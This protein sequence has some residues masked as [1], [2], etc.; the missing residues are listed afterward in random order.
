[1]QQSTRKILQV[2]SRESLPFHWHN[3]DGRREVCIQPCGGSWRWSGGFR[4]DEVNNFG[5]KIRHQNKNRFKIMP[6]DISNKGDSMVCIVN[7][8]HNDPPYRVENRLGLS[9]RGKVSLSSLP[10][11]CY[12]QCC[13]V[14]NIAHLT[15][16]IVA[17]VLE[18]G[19]SDLQQYLQCLLGH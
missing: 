19:Q 8:E 3:A 6:I 9:A 1:M 13:L 15:L 4:L 2:K 7:E 18:Q 10:V 11:F 16:S 5:L 14:F 17:L 12:M